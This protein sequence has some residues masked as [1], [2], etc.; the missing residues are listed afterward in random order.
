[1]KVSQVRANASAALNGDWVK[2]LEEFGDLAVK[3]KALDCPQADAYQAALAKN[4]LGR[5][6]MR[7]DTPPEIRDYVQC[8]T[9]IDVCVTDWRNW[10]D[11]DGNAVA[12]DRKHLEALLLK[13]AP[14]GIEVTSDKGRTRTYTTPDKM[15]YDYEGKYLYLALLGAAG[16]LDDDDGDDSGEAAEKNVSKPGSAGA[17]ASAKGK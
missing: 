11:N 1:M 9:L 3:I 15:A 6:G 5:R 8:K 16:G 4:I 7:K 13:D 12:Y 17:T 14:D 10:E 2:D